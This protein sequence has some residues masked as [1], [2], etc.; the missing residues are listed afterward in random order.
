[1]GFGVRQDTRLIRNRVAG[2]AGV[3][4]FSEANDIDAERNTIAHNV[5]DGL[6][7]GFGRSAVTGN[8]ISSNGGDG[9]QVALNRSPA[10]LATLNISRNQTD[11]NKLDGIQID[12]L[13]SDYFV[14]LDQNH[15]WFNGNLGVAA[16]PGTLGGGNWA[17]HN[18]NPAQCVPSYLCSTTGKPRG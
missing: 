13:F 7:L 8:E 5:G 10:R 3:G 15:T 9:I 16:V 4:I 2:G 6:D 18:G 12:V 14:S 17:K 11:R 1:M